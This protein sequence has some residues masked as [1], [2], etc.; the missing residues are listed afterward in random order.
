MFFVFTLSKILSMFAV[1]FKL[2]SNLVLG[3]IIEYETSLIQVR[4]LHRL[5]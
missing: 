5:R 1:C 3:M 4:I 2:N